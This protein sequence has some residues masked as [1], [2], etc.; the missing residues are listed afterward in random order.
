MGVAELRDA[1]NVIGEPAG[2][3]CS[4]ALMDVV[5]AQDTEWHVIRFRGNGPAG[6][7]DILSDRIPPRGDMVETCHATAKRLIGS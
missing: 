3:S 1:F 4:T 2:Y 6:P 5:H 7:F